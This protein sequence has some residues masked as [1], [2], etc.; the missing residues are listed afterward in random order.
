MPDLAAMA[1]HDRVLDEIMAAMTAEPGAAFRPIAVLYQD[2]LVRCRIRALP[3]AP[4]DLA[5]F[6]RRLGSAR[7][8]LEHAVT[9]APGWDEVAAIARTLPDDAQGVYLL[10]GAHRFDRRSMPPGCCLGPC[11]WHSFPCPCPSCAVFFGAAGRR[12]RL[13]GGPRLARR[14][15]SPP[16]LAHGTRQPRCTRCRRRVEALIMGF[17]CEWS[18]LPSNVATGAHEA[19]EYGRRTNLPLRG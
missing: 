2:F 16:W 10:L 11:V 1:E 18:P 13:P 7:A 8:G 5:N 14:R 19:A 6:I 17:C 15:A 12:D 4:P 9:T 3:G